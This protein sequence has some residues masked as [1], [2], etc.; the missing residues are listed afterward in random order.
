M[1]IFP[2]VYLSLLLIVACVGS[3]R[4][5][6][7]YKGEADWA[8]VCKEGNVKPPKIINEVNDSTQGLHPER[9][10]FYDVIGGQFTFQTCDFHFHVPS[11][12]TFNSNH[13]D[14]EMHI[15]FNTSP[16]QIT[17]I[18]LLFDIY[19][20]PD[21][22]NSLIQSY[23]EAK[24]SGQSY[25]FS[26]LLEELLDSCYIYHVT[27]SNQAYSTRITWI[28]IKRLLT[29]SAEQLEILYEQWNQR[30][31]FVTE[32][33]SIVYSSSKYYAEDKKSANSNSMSTKSSNIYTDSPTYRQT[34]RSNCM[35][36]ILG[37]IILISFT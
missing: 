31:E 4:S 5:S 34:N 13:A 15:F 11:E 25:R 22:D 32:N 24:N 1:F 9:I 12:H 27:P 36:I 29:I 18:A 26:F 30:P 28:V 10:D 2:A 37:I 3:A 6:K 21:A 23:I 14:L 7:K 16:G 33:G 8:F 17:V 19:D 35:K 20:R